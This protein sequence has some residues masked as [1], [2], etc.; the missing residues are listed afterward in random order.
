MK[1]RAGQNRNRGNET[2][3]PANHHR[4]LRPARAAFRCTVS[5]LAAITTRIQPDREQLFVG[6]A[7]ECVKCGEKKTNERHAWRFQGLILKGR[8]CPRR[9]ANSS[10]DLNPIGSS[11]PERSNFSLPSGTPAPIPLPIPTVDFLPRSGSLSLP[12]TEDRDRRRRVAGSWTEK[13]TAWKQ[14]D[15]MRRPLG[16]DRF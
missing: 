15:A 10:P 12:A 13:G 6:K 4:H 7:S 5:C 3:R 8:R 14:C 9:W 16:I 2:P 11:A 1:C